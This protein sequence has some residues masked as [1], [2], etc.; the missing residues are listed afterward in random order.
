MPFSI[1]DTKEEIMKKISGSQ[2]VTQTIHMGVA[3]LNYK[4]QEELLE[5]QNTYNKKQLC[6]SGALALGTWA[7]VFATLYF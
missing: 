2:G 7:L 5:K 1:D 3:F 6:L 4:L